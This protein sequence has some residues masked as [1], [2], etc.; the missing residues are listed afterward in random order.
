MY[1]VLV[2]FANQDA[3]TQVRVG[4]EVWLKQLFA[5]IGSAGLATFGAAVLIVGFA[6]FW[7]ERKQHIPLRPRF[8]LWMILESAVYAVIVAILVSGLVG[9]ILTVAASGSGVAALQNV[10]SMDLSLKLALSIGAGIY[11]ELLFRVILVGGLF[12]LAR[13]IAPRRGIA[14][15]IAAI[16]G[17]VIFSW[18]HYLGPYGDVFT[19]GSFLFRFFFG[20]VLNFIFLLRGFG[21]AAWTHALYDV[22]LVVGFLG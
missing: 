13:R 19:V 20:L 9:A 16:V 17:A 18:V 10:A 2:V 15:A 6:I 8:F 3:L 4:A 5:L 22:M 21:I 7:Y 11:E 14:Y 12:L 1:E